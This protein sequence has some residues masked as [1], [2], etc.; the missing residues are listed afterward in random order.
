MTKFLKSVS[1]TCIPNWPDSNLPTIFVYYNGEM[2]KQ[3]IGPVELRGIKLTE[4]GEFIYTCSRKDSNQ[5]KL[6]YYQNKCIFA[7]LEWMVGEIGAVPTKI[8]EDPK[9]KVHDVLFSKLNAQKDD[10]ADT[11]DW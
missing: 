1:T 8:K 9:P 11:N 2:V 6:S 10:L 7:E 4:A 5:Y 3:F